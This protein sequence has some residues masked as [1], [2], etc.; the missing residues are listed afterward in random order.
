MAGRLA[1][2]DKR[3]SPSPDAYN[4][5]SKMVEKAGKSMG[6]RLQSTLLSKAKMNDPGPGNYNVDKTKK[7]DYKYSFGTKGASDIGKDNKVPGPGNYDQSSKITIESV[8]ASKFGTGQRSSVEK[9][10]GKIVPGPGTHS[11]DFTALKSKAPNF[12]FGSEQRKAGDVERKKFVPG[13]GT[14]SIPST[15]GADG[16][17]H[18]M[19]STLSYSPERKEGGYKPGPGNYDPDI[20]KSQKKEPA[21]SMGTG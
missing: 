12:G 6:M 13:A 4:I 19:H 2:I 18:T 3:V 21:Y 15:I 11:P 17:K 9:A 14:Y 16:P 7:D 1:A 5:P 8:K 10:G 20:T